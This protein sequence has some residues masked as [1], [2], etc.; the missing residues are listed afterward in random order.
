MSRIRFL[1]SIV[2][3]VA[4][5]VGI[6]LGT[7]GMAVLFAVDLPGLNT[8]SASA[9]QS[10]V[11]WCF[12]ALLVSWILFFIERRA[13]VGELQAR[14]YRQRDLQTALDGLSD[15]S[16]RGRQ[17]SFCWYAVCG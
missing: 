8:L 11:I 6:I 9:R 14:L 12:V 10:F 5:L 7:L 1:I 3:A 13:M 15:T 2:I 4:S 16:L 17:Y